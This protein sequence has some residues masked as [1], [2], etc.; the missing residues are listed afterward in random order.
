MNRDENVIPVGPNYDENDPENFRHVEPW[1]INDVLIG[2]ISHY[3]RNNPDEGVVVEDSPNEDRSNNNNDD[4]NDDD[5]N[6]D[7]G[8]SGCE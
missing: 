2:E 4:D 1:L 7:D 6:Y 3:Y 8:G 5:D